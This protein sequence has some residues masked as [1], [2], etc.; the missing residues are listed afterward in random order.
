MPCMFPLNQSEPPGMPRVVH[1][2]Y[3]DGGSRSNGPSDCAGA[4]AGSGA[5]AS[6]GEPGGD[7]AVAGVPGGEPGGASCANAPFD[8]SRDTS[9]AQMSAARPKDVV[10]GFISFGGSLV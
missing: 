2:G 4:G 6:S 5:G 7:T 3:A 1:S 9:G 10:E 8:R